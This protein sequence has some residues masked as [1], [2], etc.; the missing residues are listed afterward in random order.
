[1][2]DFENPNLA[3]LEREQDVLGGLL[4]AVEMIPQVRPILI[5]DAFASKA[6]GEIYR[7]IMALDESADLITVPE[8]LRQSG[9]LVEVEKLAGPITPYLAT[10]ITGI[11]TPL[12]VVAYAEIVYEAWRRRQVIQELQKA[13]EAIQTG[14]TATDVTTS[15]SRAL[16]ERVERRNEDQTLTDIIA[17]YDAHRDK[18]RSGVGTNGILTGIHALDKLTDGWRPG[19]FIIVAGRPGEGK[20]TMLLNFIARAAKKD[21]RSAMFS[22]EMGADQVMRKL[23]ADVA[24]VN[25]SHSA[26]K[27]MT[28]EAWERETEAK[29]TINGWP[30]HFPTGLSYTVD[31]IAA[32]VHKLNMRGKPIGLIAVDYVQLMRSGTRTNNRVEEVSI[33]TRGLK[34]LA[35]TLQVP[36]IA[37]AQLSRAG[38]EGEP[39]LEHLRESGSIEQDADVVAMLHNPAIAAQPNNRT[40]FIRKNREGPLG[41]VPLIAL[42]H[43]SRFAGAVPL[44]NSGRE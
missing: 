34:A 6:N 15:L 39:K 17:T 10:C 35:M 29:N 1:M 16:V 19:Q 32:K 18:E 42:F 31:D 8:Y 23:V 4:A 24:G 41:E 44:D 43:I 14:R 25:T 22:F 38:A 5:A 21:V 2:S 11:A 33:I 13:A 7:A 26:V 3:N 12:N 40:L 30:L 27:S 37:A 28:P 20:S 9:K 36:I